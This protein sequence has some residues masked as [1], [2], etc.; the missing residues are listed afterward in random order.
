M[1]DKC[2]KL[3]GAKEFA[4]RLNISGTTFWRWR[5]AEVI[6]DPLNIP[7]SRLKK[8]KEEYVEEFIRSLI[9]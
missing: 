4:E 9:N 3:V 1:S 2:S 8:W 7:G 5:K 6:A